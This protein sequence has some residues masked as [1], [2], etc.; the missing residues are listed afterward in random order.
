MGAR[1]KQPGGLS[2][3]PEIR[4]G[5]EEMT[6][7]TARLIRVAIGTTA[8]SLIALWIYVRFIDPTAKDLAI[9]GVLLIVVASVLS[10]LLGLNLIYFSGSMRSTRPRVARML[11]FLFS[12]ITLLLWFFAALGHQYLRPKIVISYLLVS[13]AV[14]SAVNVVV[15]LRV[16]GRSGPR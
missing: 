2:Q 4:K 12:L 7:K 10:V 13:L 6:N 11:P 8:I 16:A 14:F 5:T 9:S 15:Y 3:R 1:H